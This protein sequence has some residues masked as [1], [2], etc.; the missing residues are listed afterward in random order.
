[1]RNE[2]PTCQALTLPVAIMTDI[3]PRQALRTPVSRPRAR[4]RN[5]L[6]TVL[7]V[8]VRFSKRSNYHVFRK[9]PQA[10]I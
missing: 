1:M 7:H 9:I 4:W 3:T 2:R 10:R 5:A 6:A 8:Q